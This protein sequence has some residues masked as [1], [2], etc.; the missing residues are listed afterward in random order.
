MGILSGKCILI[1]GGTGH[2][3]YYLVSRL[4]S[5]AAN[6]LVVARDSEKLDELRR[7]N[8]NGDIETFQCD[9]AEPQQVLKVSNRI[10]DAHS[11][12]HLA[13]YVPKISAIQNEPFRSVRDNVMATVN[14]LNHFGVGRSRICFAST[15]EVYGLPRFLPISELHPTEPRS[16]YGA[17]KLAAEVYTK[18]FSQVSECPTL[19]LRFASVYGPGETIE[20]AIPNFIKAAL[21]DSPPVIYGN[22]LDLRDYV[23][24]DDAVEAII[25]ALQ[26]EKTTGCHVYNIA[27]GQGYRIK[28]V[29]EIITGLCGVKHSPV[30]KPAKKQT[31]DYVFDISIARRDL[32]YSPKI[33]LAE[34][35]QR[36]IAW[37]KTGAKA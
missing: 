30:Y 22:G 18:V 8:P 14:V 24:I 27:S 35:L 10:R 2:I 33:S 3:G 26:Q 7:A 12:V 31:T 25:L 13:S 17:G 15:V 29:A 21:K 9:L 23:Y 36:E 5:E 20:R 28:E 16:Y 11:L 6:L 32:G 4:A 34:G 19:I 1:T 37:F